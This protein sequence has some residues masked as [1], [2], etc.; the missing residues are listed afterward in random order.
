M[1]TLKATWHVL[2]NTSCLAVLPQR[3]ILFFR[4]VDP[5]KLGYSC[6]ETLMTHVTSVQI[7]GLQEEKTQEE[8]SVG[9]RGR[10]EANMPIYIIYIICMEI[11]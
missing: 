8:R 1:Y 6:K 7:D 5:G 2:L 11:S 3:N 10:Q 9:I 4:G